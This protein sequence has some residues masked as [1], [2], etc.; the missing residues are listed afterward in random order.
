MRKFFVDGL[1]TAQRKYPCKLL[2]EKNVSKVKGKK[3]D[4]DNSL[5]RYQSL[6][7]P[8]HGNKT[9]DALSKI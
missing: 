5:Q 7:T 8:L 4:P 1:T 6:K 2:I 3:H 9:S